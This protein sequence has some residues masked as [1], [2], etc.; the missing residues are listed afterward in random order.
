MA[1]ILQP[2][3]EI[4]PAILLSLEAVARLEGQLQGI[5]LKPDELAEI[6]TLS[7]IDA[8]HYS[9]K[10][11]GNP[12]T[13]Q[14]VTKALSGKSKKSHQGRSLQEVINYSR[15][16]K[17]LIDRAVK[18]PNL[19][20]DLMLKV[21]DG[22]MSGIVRGKL[23]G[24]FREAQNVIRDSKTGQIVFMPPVPEDVPS[25]AGRLVAWYHRETL[26]RTSPLIVAPLFHYLF[27]TIHP[28][29]DGNG[30]EARL[31]TNHILHVHDYTVTRFASLEKQHEK[32]RA[33]YYESLRKLQRANFYDIP[34]DLDLSPWIE[35][36]IDCLKSTYEE[37]LSRVQKLEQVTPESGDLSSRLNKAVSLFK[38]HRRLRARDYEAIMGL[39]RTQAVDDLNQ[40]VHLDTIKKTGGGRSTIYEINSK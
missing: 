23:K 39:G 34:A 38:R 1:E 9:T 35:Y 28:F 22:L 32:N 27:V 37:A 17:M 12:L 30:R 8:V 3:Y 29:M 15:T 14:Q 21:H 19:T 7:N 18:Y 31:L 33:L 11:E 36:W 40:L 10:I 6:S 2:K 25:L 26:N 5:G 4:T 24:H 16:R 20:K 13:L